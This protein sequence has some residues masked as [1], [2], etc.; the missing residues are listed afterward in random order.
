MAF[1][2][3]FGNKPY[4]PTVAPAS[5]NP[6]FQILTPGKSEKR[7]FDPLFPGDQKVKASGAQPQAKQTAATPNN[8]MDT[9]PDDSDQPSGVGRQAI[10]EGYCETVRPHLS[11]TSSERARM[12][13]ETHAPPTISSFHYMSFLAQASNVLLQT[14]L[15]LLM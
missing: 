11:N 4:V 14:P 12:A 15:S 8:L 2:G 5:S 1:Q 13:A 6:E 9:G 7:Y 10:A 3:R